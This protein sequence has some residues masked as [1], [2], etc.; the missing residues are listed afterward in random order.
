MTYLLKHLRGLALSRPWK[1]SALLAL[2]VA[3]TP[4]LQENS[5]VD[6]APT[7]TEVA[8]RPKK[9]TAETGQK[10]Q[11]TAYRASGSSGSSADGFKR[12]AERVVKVEWIASGGTISATGEF[13]ASQPG[14]Y[15][16]AGRGRGA[17]KSDTSTVVVVPP[18]TSLIGLIVSPDTAKLTEDG[19]RTFAAKGLLSDSTVADVGVTW[20]ADG[21]T[22]DAGG[23]YLAG[24]VPGNFH[25]IATS[26]SSSLA[27]T[28]AVAIAQSST[29]EVPPVT[30]PP[31][32]VISGTCS[33]GVLIEPGTSIQAAVDANPTGTSFR[34]A[35]GIY[36]N[37]QVTPKA[38]DSF[39]GFGAVL[40]GGR[41]LTTWTSSGGS[42]Y[43]GGQTQEGVFTTSSCKSDQPGCHYPEQLWIDGTLKERVTSL[44]AVSSNTWYFDYSAD[45]I[46]IGVNPSGHAIE[47]SVPPYAFGG[48]ASG[49]TLKGLTIQHYAAA[50]PN[51]VVNA[52]LAAGWTIDSNLVQDNGGQGIAIGTNG[53]MRWNIVRRQ[54]QIGYKAQGNNGL[55]YGNQ[56]VSNN[57]AGFGIGSGGEAGC[58]KAVRTNG[59]IF[60]RNT[61]DSNDGPG[62]W[63]DIDNQHGV[64]DSNTVTNNKWRGIFYEI[65]Y[66]GEIAYNTVVGNGFDIP[67]PAGVCDGAGILISSSSDVEVHH[68]TLARNKNGLCYQDTDRPAGPLGAHDLVNVSTHHNTVTQ[69][70]NGRAAGI[71]DTDPNADPYSVGAHNVWS[72][73]TYN[74][75]LGTTKWRWSGGDVSESSWRTV[76]D[77]GSSFG[78]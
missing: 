31:A 11:L 20:T 76:Q 46:Y 34:F 32:E 19:S 15:K 44:A 28:A 18:Q 14:S 39:C 52:S 10:I 37:Q 5:N 51:A 12:L 40:D 61:C 62:P 77:A 67:G 58:G 13:S 53:K 50:R 30:P 56:F 21:G 59:L 33:G 43:A 48:S 1:L 75:T 41:V 66:S 73:N 72:S 42:W 49:V 16:I 69:T 29:T 57:T 70:D 9:V 7:E 24:A 8:I 71:T 22:I 63:Y 55:I 64:I 17:H 68:N 2:L 26:V 23:V 38:N 54:G 45:R 47:T 27:D 36:R 6:G 78:P 25:V 3:C 4:D 74:R 35:A 60:R 65:S